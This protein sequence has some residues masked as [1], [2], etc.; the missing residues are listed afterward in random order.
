MPAGALL[1]E[2]DDACGKACRRPSCQLFPSGKF[3]L[4]ASARSLFTRQVKWLAGGWS[5]SLVAHSSTGMAQQQQSKLLLLKRITTDQAAAVKRGRSALA[6][7]S[8]S[9]LFAL[10]LPTTTLLL[11]QSINQLHCGDKEERATAD[12]EKKE[13]EPISSELLLQSQSREHFQRP[14]QARPGQYQFQLQL[15]IAATKSHTH[16]TQCKL[17]KRE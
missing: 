12:S 11:N 7:A 5:V 8:S 17:V 16:H 3:R 14:R 9:L 6:F 1:F 10:L 13:Q 15:F 4:P 2:G